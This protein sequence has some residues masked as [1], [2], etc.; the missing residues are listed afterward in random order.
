MR[1]FLVLFFVLVPV[2]SVGIA[3]PVQVLAQDATPTAA[4]FPMVADPGACTGEPADINALLDAWYGAGA[5]PVAVSGAPDGMASTEIT[6]PVGSPA[7]DEVTAEIVSVVVG[8]FSCFAAGDAARAYGYFSE[9]LARAFGPEPGT[10]REDAE[11]FMTGTPQPETE[12]ERS[13]IVAITDVMMLSEGRV[14]AFVVEGF[15][16]QSLTSY[17]I[18]VQQDERWVVDEI[19][20][21]SQFDDQEA[22]TPTP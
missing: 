13:T 17:A 3:S 9:D 8:V 11:A 1:R 20:E 21:F 7:T 10:P 5:S 2:I 19:I 15:A 16:G 4:Q 12:D 14:G 6:I 18:F 22:S